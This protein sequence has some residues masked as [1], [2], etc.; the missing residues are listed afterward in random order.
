MPGLTGVVY[1][2][3]AH[4]APAAPASTYRDVILADS[5]VGYWRLGDTVGSATARAE[6]GPNLAAAGVVFGEASLLPGD[7]DT[8]AFFT[9]DLT[10]GSALTYADVAGGFSNFAGNA[11]FTAEVW[12]DPLGYAL[13]G[14]R[15][16]KRID[17]NGYG[18]R[19][20]F[21]SGGINAARLTPAGTKAAIWTTAPPIGGT[22]TSA[23]G[24]TNPGA[25]GSYALG[26]VP[27]GGGSPTT[28][29]THI[30]FVYDGTQIL[31]YVDSVLR[32]TKLDPNAIPSA[33]ATLNVGGGPT[34]TAYAV[35]DEVAIYPT[36]LGQP[37]AS[38][39][40]TA[41][42]VAAGPDTPTPPAP[43][44]AP[45]FGTALYAWL[46]TYFPSPWVNGR[47]PASTGSVTSVSTVTALSS[48]ISAATPGTIIELA[49][50]TYDF[51][52]TSYL[53]I[54]K[55]WSASNPV[56]IR[57]ANGATVTMTNSGT[58]AVKRCF[59]IVNTTGLR[60]LG[61][62][63][64][65]TGTMIFD[66]GAAGGTPANAVKLDGGNADIEFA[67]FDMTR[68]KAS[69][70]LLDGST[71]TNDRVAYWNIRSYNNSD[72]GYYLGSWGSNTTAAYSVSG[73]LVANC[74]SFDN[75]A[76]TA[77]AGQGYG[78]QIGDSVRHARIVHCTAD[79][80]G[81][82]S[83][84]EG[85]FTLFSQATLPSTKE[86]GDD[87]AFINCV[88]TNNTIYGID[89][90]GSTTTKANNYV[91]RFL[92]FGNGTADMLTSNSMWVV[93]AP[94]YHGDPKYVNRTAKDFRPS[95][96]GAAYNV[97]DPDW[98]PPNDRLGV[99]RTTSDLGSRAAV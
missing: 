22:T 12:L 32:A 82:N 36:A 42:G 10:N 30:M 19:L 3:E 53:Q 47:L 95:I 92:G 81:A 80:N 40:Y 5:P 91:T 67:D 17:A 46:A 9:G 11:P 38:A 44:P 34:E 68:F 26:S 18:W 66:G 74:E 75:Y 79:N 29:Y 98:T 49:S 37:R 83:G 8:A 93:V 69:P 94:N 24:G 59:Y 20:Y 73:M 28:T 35:L 31:L 64:D 61:K 54:A 70:M 89:A 45:T 39:H 62:S 90:A 55:V 88:G 85:G 16:I 78:F 14:G 25:F 33:A 57:P 65:G 7:A 41:A 76:G 52:P 56:T 50:G 23:S 77:G 96:S 27:A 13:G 97:G 4:G 15:V 43:P 6:V 63:A 48:A 60:V 1:R 99:A 72:H 84:R 51:N 2:R 71:G 58:T 86:H 87:V 21:D